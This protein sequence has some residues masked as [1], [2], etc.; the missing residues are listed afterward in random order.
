M[1]PEEKQRM[2]QLEA[3]VAEL[4]EW[5]RQRM[6]QQISFPVDDNSKSALGVVSKN[7]NGATTLTQAY[8]VVGG[9][10][11]TVTAGKAFIGS[12]ILLAEGTQYE[13]PYIA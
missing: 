3:L 11:G 10:G 1:T 2:A 13:I 12:V 8:S 6:V 9:G 4:T 7:G 5:K